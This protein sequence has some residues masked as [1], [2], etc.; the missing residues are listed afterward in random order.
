M[1]TYFKGCCHNRVDI[2]SF[3]AMKPEA[4]WKSG[5]QSQEQR[6]EG[7][8]LLTAALSL[9]PDT[10]FSKALGTT[11]LLGSWVVVTMGIAE[12]VNIRMLDILVRRKGY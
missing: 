8:C 5:L 12:V 1:V 6:E 9:T 3:T 10:E 7:G 11:S 2:G 4:L